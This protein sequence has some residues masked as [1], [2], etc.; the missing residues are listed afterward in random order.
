MEESLTAG[1]LTIGTEVVSGQIV[2]SNSAWIANELTNLRLQTKW[3]LAVADLRSDM[4]EA[5]R[6]LQ[7]K[8]QVLIVTGGLG[9]TSDDF[10]RDVVA[11]WA[12]KSLAFDPASWDHIEQRF[13]RLGVK[14]PESN[15][16]QCYFPQDSRILLNRQ[17]TAH[18]FHLTAH[19][20][21]CY[22]LPGPPEEIKAI[23]KDHIAAE[24]QTQSV[25][26]DSHELRRWQ[27][28]GVSESQIGEEVE[29]LIKGS[30]LVAGYRPHLPYIEIKI[31]CKSSLKAKEQFLLE[32]LD[33]ALDRW[34][35]VRDDEDALDLLL[36]KVKDYDHIH[37]KDSASLGALSQRVGSRWSRNSPVHLTF[38]EN[39]SAENNVT[40]IRGPKSLE[41]TIGPLQ[42]D[43]SWDVWYKTA[44]MQKLQTLKLPFKRHPERAMRE[45]L[46]ICEQSLAAFIRLAE[47]GNL[48]L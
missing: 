22:V 9:P 31:W 10:T 45:R 40:D 34:T 11:E 20:I 41:L 24:L 33:A 14:P 5:L 29:A 6:F 17:G 23:W 47:K 48:V 30:S 37:V 35:I 21:S 16:Q 13:Q 4:L 43:G 1:I 38:L 27:L 8:V 2:N 42:E 15:R 39:F 7:G 26:T 25:N 19:G 36:Q 46:F 44:H 28:I 12:S 32:K 3:H 18:G